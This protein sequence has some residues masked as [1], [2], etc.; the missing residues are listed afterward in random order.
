MGRVT[1]ELIH[2]AGGRE[3]AAFADIYIARRK[4]M[5]TRKL[6]VYKHIQDIYY[7]CYVYIVCL[8]ITCY[9]H[10]IHMLRILYTRHILSILQCTSIKCVPHMMN[11]F[12][13]SHIWWIIT[14]Y[15]FS[16]TLSKTVSFFTF[17]GYF[18]I[19]QASTYK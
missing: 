7:I 8:Y 17:E 9:I 13:L 18:N 4:V 16:V 1:L 5:K 3:G 12:P 11:Y 15:L 19:I 10:N 6:H 14:I 2:E